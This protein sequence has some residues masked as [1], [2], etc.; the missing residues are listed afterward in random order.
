MKSSISIASII[1]CIIVYVAADCYQEAGCS[2]SHG[3]DKI[4][5]VGQRWRPDSVSC[6]TCK[7]I[8]TKKFVLACLEAVNK[9]PNLSV[10]KSQ[11]SA[12]F[13]SPVTYTPDEDIEI[14]REEANTK[15]CSPTRAP[16]YN[17]A[18]G[19]FE[20]ITYKMVYYYYTE[21]KSRCCS[22][23]MNFTNVHPSCKVVK[24]NKCR[25]IVVRRDNPNERCNRAMS[26]IG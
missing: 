17:W 13:E 11:M 5:K 14:P 8:S 15:E 22:R 3:N 6:Y 12:R 24:I 21:K 7:C 23:F 2:N 26:L 18:T 10:K 16:I 19:T 25:S 4:Y 1:V 9:K 20:P